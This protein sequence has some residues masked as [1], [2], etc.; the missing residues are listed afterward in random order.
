MVLMG[1]LKGF[2][3]VLTG[4]LTDGSPSAEGDVGEEGPAS[5]VICPPLNSASTRRCSC[6]VIA[7]LSLIFTPCLQNDYTA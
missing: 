5:E 2:A 6:C 3:M 7:Q 4:G 1:G